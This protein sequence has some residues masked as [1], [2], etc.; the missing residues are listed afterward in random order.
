MWAVRGVILAVGIVFVVL[1]VLNGGMA[2]VLGKAIR[3]CTECIGLG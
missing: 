2:D 1:G 3:I